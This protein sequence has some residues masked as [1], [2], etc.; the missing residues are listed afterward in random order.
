M[1]FV[2]VT[3]E[4]PAQLGRKLKLRLHDNSHLSHLILIRLV[5]AMK[6][7]LRKDD[8][9]QRRASP[10]SSQFL[11]SKKLAEICKL[12]SRLFASNASQT[13]QANISLFLH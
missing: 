10:N 13:N 2:F 1:S 11:V 7:F 8:R 4:F 12:S 5:F 6:F 3:A 9:N